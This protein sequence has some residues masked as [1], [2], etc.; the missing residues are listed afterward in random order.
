MK[1]LLQDARTGELQI[2]EVPAP[3][4]LPGCVLVRVA[5]FGRHGAR[6]RGICQ[7][8]PVREGEGPSRPGA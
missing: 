2:A 5:G 3:Q 7:Q 1:Q 6:L 4:L 8:K